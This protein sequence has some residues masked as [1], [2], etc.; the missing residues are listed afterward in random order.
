MGYVF[1]RA[2]ALR[3]ATRLLGEVCEKVYTTKRP[4]AIPNAMN[5]FLVVS[6]PARIAD[7]TA[8]RETFLRVD[9]FMREK[10]G[11][12][13]PVMDL[14]ELQESILERFPVNNETMI[15]Y[16]PKL[17]GS[18]HDGIAFYYLRLQMNLLIK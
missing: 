5:Q 7:Q 16:N 12:I 14:E 13:E 10:Q 6:I 15:A 9:V 17:I 3:E 11:G 18:G 4:S 2:K 8:Y 1:K